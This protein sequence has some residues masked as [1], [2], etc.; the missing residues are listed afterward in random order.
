MNQSALRNTALVN[1]SALAWPVWGT[2][3]NMAWMTMA[4]IT[5]SHAKFRSEELA[6]VRVRTQRIHGRDYTGKL[7]KL[8]TS[9]AANWVHGDMSS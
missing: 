5:C 2:W 3:G 7:Y 4:T 1:Q 9:G 6:R 8:G